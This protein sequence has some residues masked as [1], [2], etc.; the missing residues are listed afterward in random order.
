MFQLS[1]FYYK[2]ET[3]SRRSSVISLFEDQLYEYA[4]SFWQLPQC[5]LGNIEVVIQCSRPLSFEASYK[6]NK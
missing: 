3:V 6:T 4:L 5:R 2:V 1:G